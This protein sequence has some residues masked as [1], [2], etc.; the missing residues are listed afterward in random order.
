MLL[1]WI[2]LILTLIAAP[3]R[4]QEIKPARGDFFFFFLNPHKV[5]KKNSSPVLSSQAESSLSFPVSPRFPRLG[6]ARDNSLRFWPGKG[7]KRRT[8]KS[9]RAMLEKRWRRSGGS[10]G[11]GRG[12]YQAL[13][14]VRYL[15]HLHFSS[16]VTSYTL[17]GAAWVC[18]CAR[19][20]V[21][22]CRWSQFLS[23]WLPPTCSL[24]HLSTPSSSF[25]PPQS[26]ANPPHPEKRSPWGDR[27][28]NSFMSQSSSG[29]SIKNPWKIPFHFSF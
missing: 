4:V 20:C 12:H 8:K 13:T 27:K 23:L 17:S 1:C 11:D 14:A 3:G 7:K 26:L 25:H 16:L 22:V 5:D 21:R 18:A 2:G 29:E 24:S 9:L 6:S 10:P 28:G 15:N 19:A